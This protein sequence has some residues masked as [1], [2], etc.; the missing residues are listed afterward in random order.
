MANI[1]KLRERFLSSYM[2]EGYY[3][4][5]I[6][7]KYIED[8]MREYYNYDISEILESDMVEGFIISKGHNGKNKLL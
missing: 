2:Y 4:G 1:L 5:F 7:R 6:S 3:R 8:F